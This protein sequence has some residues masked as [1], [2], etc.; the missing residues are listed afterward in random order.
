MRKFP[1]L[2]PTFK[3]RRHCGLL[4]CV[5]SC[6]HAHCTTKMSSIFQRSSSS[7]RS[8]RSLQYVL[9]IQT[10]VI[11]N[12]RD[13][14]PFAFSSRLKKNNGSKLPVDFFPIVLLTIE[15]EITFISRLM[16]Y[17]CNIVLVESQR[18]F[19]C[20]NRYAALTCNH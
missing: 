7:T 6:A 3:A 17:S 10:K 8:P 13:S 15:P 16:H 19:F 18:F 5:S 11:I 2:W 20:Y 12:L 4:I 14:S 1:W 9:I